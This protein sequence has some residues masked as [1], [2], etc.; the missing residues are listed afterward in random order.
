MWRSAGR[1]GSFGSTTRRSSSSSFRLLR[2]VQTI[3]LEST[4]GRAGTRAS[5]TLMGQKYAISLI[6][7][8]KLLFS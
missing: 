3:L 5:T 4:K 7:I 8:F 6:K 1:L 2:P